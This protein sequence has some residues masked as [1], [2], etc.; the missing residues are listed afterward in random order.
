MMSVLSVLTLAVCSVLLVASEAGTSNDVGLVK[1]PSRMLQS[2]YSDSEEDDNPYHNPKYM[3][4]IE[5][6]E[7]EEGADKRLYAADDERLYALPA[8]I[9]A[10]VS[11]MKLAGVGS[12]AITK[13]LTVTKLGGGTLSGAMKSKGGKKVAKMIFGYAMKIAKLAWASN[14]IAW[15]WA[16]WK[17]EMK[18]DLADANKAWVWTEEGW[19]KVYAYEFPNKDT[20]ISKAMNKWWCNRILTVWNEDTL[21]VEFLSKK[22]IHPWSYNTI[23]ETAKGAYVKQLETNIEKVKIDGSSV[24]TITKADVE[25]YL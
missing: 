23:M 16:R 9:P 12:T 19:G 15:P 13:A 14:G 5:M 1:G 2:T 4:M 17:N 22:G 25:E 8:L 6:E 18:L 7:E 10:F 3:G 20:A 21:E 24:G 11:A